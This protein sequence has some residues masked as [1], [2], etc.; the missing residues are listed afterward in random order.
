MKKKTAVFNLIL[1]GYG[2]QLSWTLVGQATYTKRSDPNQF[3]VI[4]LRWVLHWVWGPTHRRAIKV[5]NE[6]ESFSGVHSPYSDHHSVWKTL[7]WCIT[8]GPMPKQKKKKKTFCYGASMFVQGVP[9]RKW[10]RYL[11]FHEVKNMRLHCTRY[12]KVIGPISVRR[13][14]CLT[15]VGFGNLWNYCCLF[16][17]NDIVELQSV[18]CWVVWSVWCSTGWNFGYTAL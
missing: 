7:F 5:G 3:Y 18:F 14:F 4:A 2:N 1:R 9:Q 10:W 12:F 11:T 6:A 15:N 17:V 16:F 8:L 13:Q